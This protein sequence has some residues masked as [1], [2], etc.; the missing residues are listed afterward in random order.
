ME[1]H[2]IRVRN[3]RLEEDRF[4]EERGDVLKRWRTGSEVDLLEA[5]EYLKTIPEEKNVALKV[6]KAKESGI[7][8]TQP[9]GGFPL[10]ESMI[11]LHRILETE[12]DKDI[13]LPVT[14]DSYTRSERFSD[15]QQ[16]L[17]TS[18]K[19]NRRFLNG[20]PVVNHGVKNC[21]KLQQSSRSPLYGLGG[22]PLPCLTAEISFASGITGFIGSGV[23]TPVGYSK[24]VTIEQGIK[25]Y[26]YVDRLVSF[27]HENGIPLYRE[28]TG[29]LTWILVPPGIEIALNVID[30][31]L[32]A[33]QGIKYYGLGHSAQLNLLQDAASVLV[34]REMAKEYLVKFGHPDVHLFTTL[35][36]YGG[37]FPENIAMAYGVI[38]M[39]AAAAGLADVQGVSVKTVDECKSIPTAENNALGVKATRQVLNITGKNRYPR[40]P[41]LAFEI[42]FLKREVRAIL[43]R[44]FE[45]GDGELA[46]GTVLAF[47]HGILDCPWSPNLCVK[48]KLMGARDHAGMLRYLSVGNVPV[49]SDILDYHREALRKRSERKKTESNYEMIMEDLF[50]VANGRCLTV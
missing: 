38:S 19:E 40:T 23:C 50:S 22:N 34:L 42:E 3:K 28:A 14:T 1:Q 29:F 20:F 16:A 13:L 37:S 48:G 8:L 5:V 45:L 47:E 31:L 35:L 9:R 24:Y 41:E 46:V 4:F 21:R 26:Q 10:L 6:A 2:S 17:E 7:C 49:P 32:A 12:G 36:S 15:V 33:E 44:V 27:Y 25:N 30:A 18:E 39:V 43:D 11:H